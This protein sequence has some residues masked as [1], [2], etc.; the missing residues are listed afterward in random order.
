MYRDP[1]EGYL[2]REKLLA[3]FE[4][5]VPRIT[6]IA[7]FAVGERNKLALER[8]L[9]YVPEDI[10]SYLSTSYDRIRADMKKEL[11][12]KIEGMKK[13]PPNPNFGT[14]GAYN[15]ANGYNQACTDITRIIKEI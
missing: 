12:G 11:V 3:E 6:G 2:T 4:K 8:E 5:F 1:S 13:D 10:K 9:K 14:S 7:V 15:E